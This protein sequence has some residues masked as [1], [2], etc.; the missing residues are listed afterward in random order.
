MSYQDKLKPISS[1]PSGTATAP[2]SGYTAKLKPLSATAPANNPPE[3]ERD[4]FLKSMVKDAAGT[5]LVKP[6]ARTT[7]AL[8]RL[9]LFGNTI[10]TGYEAIADSGQG[11]RI[12]GIDV[13][14]Q[15][16]FKDGGAKQ[17]GG[18][19]L[20]TASYLYSGGAAAPATSAAA[21]ATAAVPGASS[22]L[23]SQGVRQAA[24]Q[25][26]KIGAIGGG[27]YAAG[28]EMTKRDSTV[29]SILGQGAVGAGLGAVTGG[30]IGTAIPYA[31]KALN[32][33]ERVARQATEIQK[34]LDRNIPNIKKGG[35]ANDSAATM[36]ALRDLDIEGAET[37]A[38][39]VRLADERIQ[40]IKTAKENIINTNPVTKRLDEFNT[41]V[42]GDTVNHVAKALDQL[43]NQYRKINALDKPAAR[44]IVELRQKAQDVGL[45]AKELDEIAVIS[46][47]DL[48]SFN[49]LTGKLESGTTKQAVENAR[50]GVK[51]ASRELFDQQNSLLKDADEAMSDLIRFRDI[52][53]ARADA[54]REY[55][56]SR[57]DPTF[58]QKIQGLLGQVTNIALAGIPRAIVEQAMRG[59]VNKSIKL[60][61]IEME[62]MLQKDMELIQAAAKKGASEEEVI[63]KLQ[64]FIRRNGEEPV[65]LLEAPKNQSDTLFGTP[66]GRMTPNAQEAS[67]VAAVELGRARQPITDPVMYQRKVR[68][69]QDRLEPYLTPEEM[70]VIQMGPAPRA[71]MQGLPA[72][73]DTPPNVYANPAA[74]DRALQAKLERY[75]T[76]EEM[77][78]IQMG[79]PPKNLFNGPTIEY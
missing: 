77:A 38:D 35:S 51:Q 55:A 19:A 16:G 33:A 47:S 70:A 62:K 68:E 39:F 45:T 44:R 15:R 40:A 43:E 11:Q 59:G 64:E 42:G 18:E 46:G 73:P 1:A 6:A 34:T 63:S 14:K 7:E 9:G 37:N 52:R 69:I 24:K 57:I 21:R 71:N 54:V 50:S 4:G 31:V 60:N 41:Q 10:K 5:L 56:S 29:G 48:K 13:D 3:P 23:F 17:I 58:R 26:A 49:L 2:Q 76:P 53:Q 65:L 8:G 66:G 25:G 72:A 22:R 27:A 78:V 30:A 32:P 36:S 67:D 74:I 75:L 61:P 79:P 12:M 28:D 20:K